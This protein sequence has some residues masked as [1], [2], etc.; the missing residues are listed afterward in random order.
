MINDLLVKARNEKKISRRELASMS[1]ISE[2]YISKIEKGEIK[3]PSQRIVIALAKSLKQ[4]VSQWLSETGFSLDKSIESMEEIEIKNF[5]DIYCEENNLEKNNQ[6]WIIS[7]TKFSEVDSP[8]LFK[9]VIENLKKDIKIARE[10]T[11]RTFFT[12]MKYYKAS[13]H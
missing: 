6:V 8:G 13:Q 9:T 2:R 11:L 7:S 1:G 3:R 5:H 10:K 12:V 4:N